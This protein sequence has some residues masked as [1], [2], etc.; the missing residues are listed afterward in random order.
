MCELYAA[1]QKAHSC[2]S[3]GLRK[4]QE[5]PPPHV[6]NSILNRMTGQY[7]AAGR[8]KGQADCPGLFHLA[9]CDAEFFQSGFI[10]RGITVIQKLGIA[11]MGAEYLAR[12]LDRAKILLGSRE[13]LAYIGNQPGS[14][15]TVGTVEFL[16]PVEVA[17]MLPVKHDVVGTLNFHN[18]VNRE[19]GRLVEAHTQV[20]NKQWDDHEVDDGPGDEVLRPVSH[21]PAEKSLLEPQVCLSDGAFEFDALSLDLEEHA[22]LLLLQCCL[23]IIF[24]SRYLV[25]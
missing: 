3:G 14:I 15:G 6:S 24:E 20:Q 4:G 5:F 8:G 19:T 23:Q 9:E 21:Q 11:C 22:G 10:V 13:D 16:D 17:E 12:V 25:E 7:T 2:C 1:E 18:F